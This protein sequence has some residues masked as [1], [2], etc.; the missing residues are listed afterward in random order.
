[1]AGFAPGNEVSSNLSA[2]GLAREVTYNTPV[3][4]SQFAP[5]TGI[6]LGPETGLFFPQTMMG[7]R[8]TDVFALYGQEKLAGALD[9]PLFPHNGILAWIGAVGNDGSQS[10]SSTTAKNGTIGA[11]SAGVTTLTYTTT[12]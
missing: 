4:P 1:M 2:V 10:G 3:T 6:T 5:F 9:S 11:V 8:E 7:I 12:A